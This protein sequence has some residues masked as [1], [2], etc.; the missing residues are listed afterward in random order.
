MILACLIIVTAAVVL[1]VASEQANDLRYFK[2]P[3]DLAG[4]INSKFA[5][6]VPL[7][8]EIKAAKKLR[9]SSQPQKLSQI[10]LANSRRTFTEF[11]HGDDFKWSNNNVNM[12]ADSPVILNHANGWMLLPSIGMCLMHLLAL[13]TRTWLLLLDLFL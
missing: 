2:R 10:K 7:H 3:S 13:L 4:M 1:T 11:L 5:D 8:P 9:L 12:G 6:L